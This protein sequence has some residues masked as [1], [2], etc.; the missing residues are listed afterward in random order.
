MN[1]MASVYEVLKEYKDVLP[2]DEG[3]IGFPTFHDIVKL[4]TLSGGSKS[5]FSTYYI[6]FCHEKSFSD[7]M[8]NRIG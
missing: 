4:F 8:L 3:P 6:K 1:V 5:G 2:E 7:D